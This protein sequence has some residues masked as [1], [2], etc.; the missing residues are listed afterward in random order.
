MPVVHARE[1]GT[2]EVRFVTHAPVLVLGCRITG[3]TLNAPVV[4]LGAS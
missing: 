1:D 2:T 4:R 3:G